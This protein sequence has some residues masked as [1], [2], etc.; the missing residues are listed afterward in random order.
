[1]RITIHVS[2]RLGEETRRAARTESISVSRLVAEALSLYLKEMKR[3]QLGNQVL[4]LIG[5]VEVAEDAL[6][7]LDEVRSDART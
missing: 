6:D 3:R 1:M 7:S 4:G 2:D 5:K